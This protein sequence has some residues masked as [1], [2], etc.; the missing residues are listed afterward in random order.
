MLDNQ[1]LREYPLKSSSLQK[2]S[3]TCRIETIVQ[4]NLFWWL[5]IV[6]HL[7]VTLHVGFLS[8]VTHIYLAHKHRMQHVCHLACTFFYN[9]AKEAHGTVFH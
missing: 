1:Q 7:T 2:F 6:Q 4:K 9:L 5:V 8:F 3:Q